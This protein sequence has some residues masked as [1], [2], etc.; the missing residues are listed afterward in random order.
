MRG[1]VQVTQDKNRMPS[2]SRDGCGESGG[3]PR[4]QSQVVRQEPRG[5]A[6]AGTPKRGHGVD[7]TLRG[8]RGSGAVLDQPSQ[9]VGFSRARRP[10]EDTELRRAFIREPS[11]QRGRCGLAAR[12]RLAQTKARYVRHCT[13]PVRYSC[14]SACCAAYKIA[15]FSP[16]SRDS[17]VT[18]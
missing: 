2:I 14:E 1:K 4:R 13:P 10:G 6:K 5:T 7:T 12:A 11:E 3:R 9:Q 8:V 15:C 16:S 18:P 17:D